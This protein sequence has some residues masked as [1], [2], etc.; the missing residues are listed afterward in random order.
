MDLLWILSDQQSARP[1]YAPLL[2]V[3]EGAGIVLGREEL[4]LVEIALEFRLRLPHSCD[5]VLQIDLAEVCASLPSYSSA[6]LGFQFASIVRSGL[7]DDRLALRVPRVIALFKLQKGFT[8]AH[9][10]EKRVMR[11]L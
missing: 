2:R 9:F 10:V 7:L 8:L 11:L 6:Q 4:G 3:E 5:H 1:G